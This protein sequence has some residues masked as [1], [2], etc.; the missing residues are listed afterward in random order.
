VILSRIVRFPLSRIVMASCCVGGVSYGT[1]RLM[2]RLGI[3]RRMYDLEGSPHLYA[4]SMLVSFLAGYLAYVR[5]VERRPAS[6][7]RIAPAPLELGAGT[8]LGAALF[9]LTIGAIALAGGYHVT[10]VR[11]LRAA[12]PWILLFLA[13]GVAEEILVRGVVFRIVEEWLGTWIALAVSSLLFGLAHAANPHATVLGALAIALEAGVLLAAGFVLTRRLWLP[14]GVHFGWNFAQ[15]GIF[16]VA[17]S[18]IPFD[19]VLKSSL[20][21]PTILSGGDFGAEASIFA[22][23]FCLTAGVGLLARARRIGR[24]VPAPWTRRRAPGAGSPAPDVAPPR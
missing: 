24:F 13:S 18:G 16:G 8:L 3:V 21:G 14:I 20:S 4:V 15:G 7:L 6:E 19:G 22:L 2:L 1:Q 5:F 9:A 17:V 10:E 11:G 23:V 12:L